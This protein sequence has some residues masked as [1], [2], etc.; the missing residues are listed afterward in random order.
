M[1]TIKKIFRLYEGKVINNENSKINIFEFD[2]IDF[3][4]GDLTSNTI[5]V[6]KI[7]EISSTQL[8]GCYFNFE[9]KNFTFFQCEKDILEDVK[10]ELL[11]RLYKP[12]YIP[13]IA[14]LCCFLIT[15]SKNN[16]KYF[17]IRKYVFIS[18]F[19]LLVFSE[20]SSSIFNVFKF[21]YDSIFCYSM[22]NIFY[23]V[24][25]FI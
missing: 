9:V 6:P 20:T 25:T 22:V 10:Q 2:Q 24:H 15:S 7:Q 8:L 23:R 16:I 17:K 18:T 14:I 12:I 4:L 21:Y 1:I 11:K 5:L 19:F 13:I 3:G